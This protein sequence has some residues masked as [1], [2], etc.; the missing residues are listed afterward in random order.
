LR[1]TAHFIEQRKAVD[2]GKAVEEVTPKPKRKPHP[3]S[4]KNLAP[5]WPKGTS[6]NPGGL[7]GTDLAALAAR[8]FFARHPS[9]SA[10]MIREL[11]GF[12]GY[13][14]ATLADR[15]FGKVVDKQLI[16]SSGVSLE[17]VLRARKKAWPDRPVPQIE[18]PPVDTD[19][20]TPASDDVPDNPTDV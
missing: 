16:V 19:A 3:N 15:A 5:P 10:A 17:D 12:N 4:L 13:G 1:R 20:D 7:P 9:I 11:R 8:E 18:A 6:G 14:F 2:A